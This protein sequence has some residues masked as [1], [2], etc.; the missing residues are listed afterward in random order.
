MVL[1]VIEQGMSWQ[2][3]WYD[4]WNKVMTVQLSQVVDNMTV[5]VEEMENSGC[6]WNEPLEPV[7]C[8]FDYTLQIN[9]RVR[10]WEYVSIY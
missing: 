9:D 4:H 3:E 5:V 6:N 8:R 10:A 2:F 1:S 7:K